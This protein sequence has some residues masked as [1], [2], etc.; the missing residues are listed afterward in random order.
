MKVTLVLCGG[1]KSPPR[2]SQFVIIRQHAL[3]KEKL[4]VAGLLISSRE[5]VTLVVNFKIIPSLI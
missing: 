2:S 1:V 4:V 5:L 3:L